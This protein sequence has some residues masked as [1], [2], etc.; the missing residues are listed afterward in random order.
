MIW[1]SRRVF[2]AIMFGLSTLSMLGVVANFGNGSNQSFVGAIFSLLFAA[3][4]LSRW[5]HD[6][7]PTK[8]KDTPQ[9]RD[10]HIE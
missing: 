1:V 8:E 5:K 6:D 4:G 7:K 9:K 10:E 2:M 3:C